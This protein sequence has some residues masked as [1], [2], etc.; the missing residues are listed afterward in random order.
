MEFTSE[1]SRAARFKNWHILNSCFNFIV[2]DLFKL[3]S[4]LGLILIA[5]IHPKICLSPF[6]F[7]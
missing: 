2:V 1:S 7:F 3:L 5:C 6:Y 4:H